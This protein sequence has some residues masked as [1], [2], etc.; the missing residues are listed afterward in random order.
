MEGSTVWEGHGVLTSKQTNI[1]FYKP[2]CQM[3]WWLIIQ[4]IKLGRDECEKQALNMHNK[5]NLHFF[6]IQKVPKFEYAT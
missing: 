5:L 1:Y 2:S 3:F 4:L 6:L